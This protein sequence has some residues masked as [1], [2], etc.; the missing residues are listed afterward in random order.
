MTLRCNMNCLHCG[1][2]AGKSRA[3]E[4][5]ESEC[6]NIAEQLIKMGN[7]HITLIGGEIFLVPH[8]Y[9]VAKKFADSGVDVNI[10][11]NG[12]SVGDRQIAELK[13]S[14]IK[15]VGVSIDGMKHNHDVIRNRDGSFDSAINTIKHLNVKNLTLVLQQQF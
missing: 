10:I 12:F 14:G 6:M 9:K 8:W 5:S 2:R 13:Q 7:E 11:T 3:N 4:L 15:D 1:S